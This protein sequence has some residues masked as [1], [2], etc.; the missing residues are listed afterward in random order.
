VNH[1]VRSIAVLLLSVC[2][3]QGVRA[4]F[5]VSG[6]GFLPDE[7]GTNLDD[8]QAK[9][10]TSKVAAGAIIKDCAEC[11]EMVV[12]PAGSFVMGSDKDARE[13]PPHTVAIRSFLMGRTEVTQNLWISIMGKNP[14][15]FK[16]CGQECPVERV[17]WDDIQQFIA[18]LNQKTGQTYRLPS[19]AEW[20]YAARAGTDTDWSFGNDE[21]KLG[22]YGWYSDN[23]GDKTQKTRQKL[24]NAFGLYDM[25]GNV[26]EWTQDCYHWNY[27]GAPS[28]GSAWITSCADNRR[29]IRGG[30]F[31]GSARFFRS[32]YRYGY[33]LNMPN[34]TGG[35]RLARDLGPGFLPEENGTNLD[36]PQG[37]KASQN[38][39][40]VAVLKDC[41][42]CPEM[43]VIP[44]G[45]FVMGSDKNNDEKPPHTV[46]IR[47]YAIGKTEVTQQQWANVMGSNPSFFKGCGSECPVESINFDEIQNFINRLNQKTG[48][49]YRLPSEAEWEYA[50]RAGTMTE[51]SF[52]DDESKLFSYGWYEGNSGDKTHVVG[53]KLPNAFGLFDMHG[54]V[55]E[56][57]KDCWHSD[58]VGAPTSGGAWEGNCWERVR[59]GGSWSSGAKGLRS[60][61]RSNGG[62]YIP[63]NP[64]TGFRLA[65]DL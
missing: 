57:T 13:Q 40:A 49:K 48:K 32:A 53:Q 50:A 19:E 54:N 1:F 42:E 35:F 5:N 59:R 44:A 9:K 25:H 20:E 51:W 37:G 24:P 58:Y 46:T 47:S 33:D 21:S 30:S 27:I 45:S 22:D 36:A 62:R 41:A 2:A 55:W 7:N 63:G 12:I 14:S 18:R 10:G 31:I 17:G 43:V 26:W 23:S 38:L 29:V 8:P 3:V 52:G 34:R 56:F 39:A 28:D 60:A 16:D 61:F 6:P 15:R 65:R 4:Q 11:P 64:V